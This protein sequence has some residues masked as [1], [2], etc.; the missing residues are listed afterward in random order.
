MGSQT[1]EEISDNDSDQGSQRTV[2]GEAAGPQMDVKGH[3]VLGLSG[4]V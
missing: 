1:H 2:K 3:F 4:L